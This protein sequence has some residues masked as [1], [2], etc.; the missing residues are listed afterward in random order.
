MDKPTQSDRET[1]PERSEQTDDRQ[2]SSVRQTAPSDTAA[3]SGPDVDTETTDPG[4]SAGYLDNPPPVYPRAAQRLRQ[5]GEVRLLVVV[6]A[7]G[8]PIDW[9]VE[10]SSGHERLDRAAMEAVAKWRFEPA[11]R[12]GNAVQGEVIV[13]LRFKLR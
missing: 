4:F 9:S 2:E 5:E 13:P 1:A 10:R 12:G 3:N 6:D 8:R 7:D 11:T